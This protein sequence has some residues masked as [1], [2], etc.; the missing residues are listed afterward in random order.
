[1]TDSSSLAAAVD[2]VDEIYN[3]AAQSDVGAS[4]SMA[5]STFDVDALGV[6]RLLETIRNV[7]HGKRNVRLYQAGTSE[8]FGNAPAP[9]NEQTPFHPRS[10]YAVAKVAAHHAVV[11]YREAYGLWAA[12]G[13]LFNHESPRRGEQFVTRKVVKAAVEIAAGKRDSLG[14]G[15]LDAKRDWGYAPEYV[16]A[17]WL[18]LQADQPDDYVVA[19]GYSYSVAE[20]CSLAFRMVGLDWR[21]YVALDPSQVRPTDVP[22]LRGDPRK[23]ER[24]LRWEVRTQFG[25]LIRLMLEAEEGYAR[26]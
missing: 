21:G 8:M 25:A 26:P 5:E 13:I 9:Q 4:F 3:L 19:T 1:M 6:I 10:P 22:E 14:L 12:N 17:M 20:L 11:H 16:E 2:G 24:R 15:S 23:A 18:M 7:G